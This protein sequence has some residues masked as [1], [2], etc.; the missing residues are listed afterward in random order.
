MKFNIPE[1]QLALLFRIV[2]EPLKKLGCRVWIFGSRARLD[3]HEYSDIDILFDPLPGVELRSSKIGLIRDAA[4]ES[5]LLYKVD[6][7]RLSDL[8]ESYLEGVLEDR[9]EL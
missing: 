7:V 5:R 9:V 8:A 2:I 3:N 1:E 4:E 6:L